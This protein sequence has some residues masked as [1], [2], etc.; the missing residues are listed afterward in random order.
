MTTTEMIEQ[1]WSEL[2]DGGKLDGR[3]HDLEKYFDELET[4]LRARYN[5]P[6]AA[7]E[8]LYAAKAA[9]SLELKTSIVVQWNTQ[10]QR[11]ARS[12]RLDDE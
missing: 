3:V 7:L 12:L 5:T 4:K 10:A 6:R 8:L 9:A 1:K 2:T 11:V